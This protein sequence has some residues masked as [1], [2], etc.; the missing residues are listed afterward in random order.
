MA[1][2]F[3]VY[4]TLV[5]LAVAGSA[6]AFFLRNQRDVTTSSPQAYHYFQI[7][8]ENEQKLYQREAIAAY[9]EA[10]KYDPRFLSAAIR[11]EMLQHR[12]DSEHLKSLL[13][14]ARRD[15][16]AAT[17]HERLEG[18]ILWADLQHDDKALEKNVNEYIRRFPT[19]PEGYKH[20]AEMLTK[21]KKTDEAIAVFERLLS[22]DPNYAIAYNNLG[23]YAMGKGDFG[24]AE[25]YLKRYRFLAPDQANPYDS[26]GELYANTG[27][28][29]DA[30]AS[31]KKAL[32]IKPDF[33]PSWA[34]L[35][36]VE[37][38]RGNMTVAA[39]DFLKALSLAENNFLRIQWT[40]A[41]AYSLTLAGDPGAGW[42]QVERLSTSIRSL[43]EGQNRRIQAR[44][45]LVRFALSVLTNHPELSEEGLRQLEET[46]AK[47][48]P[49]DQK[50]WATELNVMRG[51][52]AHSRGL[53]Q[54]AVT[55]FESGLSDAM[56]SFGG[57]E[58]FPGN[59][60]VRM[61][62]AE[63]L[64]ALGRMA[65]AEKVLA[66]ILKRNPKF[67]P[68]LQVVERLGL[69]ATAV[70][71]AAH[72]TSTPSGAPSG[73]SIAGAVPASRAR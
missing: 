8:L 59:S 36:T 41:A 73:D 33:G 51:L 1:R 68:A 18:E 64:K 52:L 38:G 62:Y 34:H 4:G 44:L 13:A 54:D 16:A 20:L 47:M 14:K 6:A 55:A 7:G 35:G 46:V 67:Q 61:A 22:V 11:L 23:Y 43:P 40:E 31:L 32:E 50:N 19:D 70:A 58:Y 27:R 21:K 42:D 57:F 17:P 39:R 66:P 56:P 26:L 30:E 12:S 48:L 29:E 63:D 28:Y 9:A 24:K 45:A 15:G 5:L 65:E 71:A 53:H 3:I 60:F 72:V 25:D 10:L 49:F 37:V 2:R 69:S